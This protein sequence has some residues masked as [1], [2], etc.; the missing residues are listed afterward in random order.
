M[1]F[2]KYQTTA[3]LFALTDPKLLNSK[4]IKSN[5]S[6][7]FILAVLVPTV[8]ALSVEIATVTV[9]ASAPA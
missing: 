8:T 3:Y 9:V 2:I 5:E 6:T 7:G 4:I 1:S